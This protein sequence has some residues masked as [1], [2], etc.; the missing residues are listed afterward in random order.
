LHRIVGGDATG[1][2][3]KGDNNQSVDPA[4]P[5][6]DMLI[7]RA[8][9]HLPKVGRVLNSPII[10]GLA[11]LAALLLL[12]ALTMNSRRTLPSATD[13]VI[14]KHPSKSYRKV[15]VG[16]IV[17]D[18][19]LLSG[20]GFAFAFAEH[21]SEPGPTYAQTGTLTYTAQVA[22]SETYPTGA[23]EPGDAVFT[24]LVHEVRVSFHHDTDAPAGSVAGTVQ[25]DLSLSTAA[26]WHSL[27]PLAASVPLQG[28]RAALTATLNLRDIQSLADRVSEATGTSAR[29]VH[30]VISASG[31]A[32]MNGGPRVAYKMEFPFE[33]SP[34]ALTAVGADGAD[35]QALVSSVALPS[36]PDSGTAVNGLVP[37]T[38]KVP[39]IVALL[40]SLG[41]TVLLWP[42]SQADESTQDHGPLRTQV[43]VVELPPSIVRVRVLA[44]EE[45]E[46]IAVRLNLP[47]LEDDKGWNGV[48]TPQALY[49]TGSPPPPAGPAPPPPPPLPRPR[50]LP[51]LQ[52]TGTT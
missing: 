49:W 21:P 10:R 2:E 28:G 39:I 29:V 19:L 38:F 24:K 13:A 8:V 5:S 27:V 18:L 7:G 45:L 16:L 20:V 11:L 22:D 50:P 35:A 51:G 25:L 3:F 14:P 15:W 17:L 4:H 48:L 40:V 41:L 30:I 37:A 6:S 34:F 44:N 1:W 43:G 36:G 9:L 46:A 23:I 33:L 12:G 42:T 47:V 31:S 26:G 32:T 52:W